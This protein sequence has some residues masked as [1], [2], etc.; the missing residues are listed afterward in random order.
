MIEA[1]S[2]EK[3]YPDGTVALSDIT[4]TINEGEM[5]FVRGQSGAGKTTLFKLL[6]GIESPSSGSLLVDGLSMDRFS[7]ISLRGLRRRAGVVFQDF[8]LLKGRTARENVELGMRVLG[9]SGA[10][11]SSRTSEYLEKLQLQDKVDTL[12]ELL[13]WGQQQRLAMARALARRPTLILADEPTGNLDEE[14]AARVLS[15]LLE[16]RGGGATVL[17]AT[18]SS[19]ILNSDHR[20]VTLQHGRLVH[21]THRDGGRGHETR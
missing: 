18:H 11:M 21:D 13:S 12:V 4:L 10:E 19:E 3:V 7:P 6:M 15:L 17:V 20:I 2:L 5:V 16:A 1:Q 8:R 9:I 14:L